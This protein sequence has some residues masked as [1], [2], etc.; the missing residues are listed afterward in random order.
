MSLFV[1]HHDIHH[2]TARL[3]W[4]YIILN[5][6]L[7]SSIVS[8][9]FIPEAEGA[10]LARAVLLQHLEQCQFPPVYICWLAKNPEIPQC[11]SSNLIPI[12]QRRDGVFFSVRVLDQNPCKRRKPF[13]GSGGGLWTQSF[14]LMP[15]V[16]LLL[17]GQGQNCL[18]CRHKP[19][20]RPSPEVECW[21]TVNIFFYLSNLFFVF[22]VW[23]KCC[24][25]SWNL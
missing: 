5:I 9:C 3:N 17:P 16:F 15:G 19:L 13:P 12:L 1:S 22:I 23:G 6:C 14:G 2:G 11:V 7:H 18:W 10:I 21:E 20:V 8:W 24:V 4:A 25:I